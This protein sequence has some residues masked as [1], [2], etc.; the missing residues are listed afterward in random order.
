[1]AALLC[2]PKRNKKQDYAVLLE[3]SEIAK[4]HLYERVVGG[5]YTNL[6]SALSPYS[7]SWKFLLRISKQT[8]GHRH[9]GCLFRLPK[10]RG[11]KSMECLR[12]LLR[13]KRA[14]QNTMKATKLS[15]KCYVMNSWPELRSRG[16]QIRLPSR[17]MSALGV[18][19]D[20][21]IVLMLASF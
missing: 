7:T 20:Y 12:A 8:S 1:M 6:P 4:P 5:V 2:F 19:K 21:T 10:N 14:F 9:G 16:L 15:K 3:V 11:S 18:F 17:H 13:S